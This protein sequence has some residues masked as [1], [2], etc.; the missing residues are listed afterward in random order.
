MIIIMLLNSPG[1]STGDAHCACS[2]LLLLQTYRKYCFS[3][4]SVCLFAVY[5]GHLRSKL[6]K[7]AQRSFLR[8][9]SSTLGAISRLA[10]FIVTKIAP[11]LSWC[12]PTNR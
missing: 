4:T 6:Q 9:S 10:S 2:H 3:C 11:F 8:G 1:G 12:L 7:R 5:V